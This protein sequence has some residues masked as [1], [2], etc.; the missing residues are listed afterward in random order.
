[1]I[2]SVMPSA[3]YSWSGFFEQLSSG[4][5]TTEARP[6]ARTDADCVGA[7]AVEGTAAGSGACERCRNSTASATDAA[8]PTTSAA[9][10]LANVYQWRAFAFF[11]FFGGAGLG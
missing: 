9:T 7:A 6:A 4:R 1:M 3:K 5:T 11:F 10:R 2:A 8:A